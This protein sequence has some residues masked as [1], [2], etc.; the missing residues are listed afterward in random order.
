MNAS[1]EQAAA[2]IPPV[3]RPEWLATRV[4]EAIAPDL[5]IIDAHHHI[6]DLPGGRYLFDE[7]LAEIQ[8]CG[9]NIEA[10]V[11]LECHSMYRA[12]GPEEMKPVGET[13]FVAGLAA[14]S[15]SGGYG[16][17]RLCKAIVGSVDLGLGDRVE[18]VL[19]ALSAAGGG[20]FRGIRDRIAS[21]PEARINRFGTPPGVLAA[22]ATRRAMAAIARHGLS[23]DI[24]AYQHQIADVLAAAKAFEQLPIVIDHF[25]G[26][27]G[28]GRSRQ[29]R[30][31]LF[32]DWKKGV[33]AL[34]ELPNVHMKISGLG[35]PYPGFDFFLDD[36]APSSDQ[37]V[38]A[39]RPFFD[40][41]LEAFGPARCMVASNFPVDKVSFSY[42]TMWNAFKK[43][44]SNCSD[45][46][47]DALFRG[48]AKRFYRI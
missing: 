17:A 40:V 23:F 21:H 46:E 43:L 10:S 30:D 28:Y 45:D 38:A 9:H 48:T 18:P 20:R 39:W 31:A 41:C 7:F 14:Q 36:A 13:E 44:A 32:V 33:T 29:E 3:V 6:W 35:M 19:D 24:W 42:S 27:L 1:P 16:P 47:Q 26:P 37:L 25:G 15:E 8:Q 34:A 22:D 4:E 11:F 12:D 2:Y 5:P